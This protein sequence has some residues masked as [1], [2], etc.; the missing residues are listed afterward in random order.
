HPGA[1]EVCNGADDDCD[2]QIDEGFDADRDTYT[3]CGTVLP[4]GGLNPAWV[5]CNDTNVNVHPFACDL[6]SLGSTA[7]VVPC[8]AMNDR[9]NGV[10]DNCNGAIDETCSPCDAVDHDGDRYSACMGDCNDAD[11][12]VHPGAAELCDGKDNDCN[13]HSVENCSV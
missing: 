9:G 1:T 5:D 4:G 3:T 13:V 6:C 2:G 11:T 7:N 12:T 10:D 8:G